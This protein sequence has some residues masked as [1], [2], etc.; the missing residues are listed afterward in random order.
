MRTI[1]IGIIFLFISVSLIAKPVEITFWHSLG[2]NIKASVEEMVIEYNKLNP[3]V[4]VKPVFQGN[5][6]E[7]QIKML[8]AAI[9]HALPDVAQ[10]QV[11]WIDPYIQNG[12]IEPI[13][14]RIQEEDR[15]DIP[16][17]MW[18]LTSRDG[19][20]YGIPFCISTT[21]FFYNKDMLKKAA[22]DPEMP[23]STWEEMIETGERIVE[24]M[25]RWEKGNNY[26]VMLWID[27]F[28]GIAP[29]FWVNGGGLFSEDGEKVNLASEEMVKTMR[30]ICDL[31][32]VHK[33][34][35]QKWS[36]WEAGQA[37]L[38]GNLIMGPFTSVAIAYG[39]QNLPWRLGVTHIPSINGK[40]FTVLSGSAL[41]NFAKKKEVKAASFDFSL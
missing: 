21:V 12:I 11:E 40:R 1:L 38:T 41:V 10:V 36:D 5:F 7:M 6:E 23:P 4:R 31:V 9:T 29:F 24:Y 28:Y 39:E 17:K 34:M 15:A 2:F 33:I 16:Q 3:D 22:L 32:F 37:F 25:D 35:P 27:G 19:H 8:S 26:A 14:A 18:E 13:E 20:V 30:Q